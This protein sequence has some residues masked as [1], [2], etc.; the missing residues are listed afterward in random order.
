MCNY[1]CMMKTKRYQVQYSEQGSWVQ[2]T[3]THTPATDLYPL[4]SVAMAA[5]IERVCTDLNQN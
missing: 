1:S 4:P 5:H 2:D 3:E